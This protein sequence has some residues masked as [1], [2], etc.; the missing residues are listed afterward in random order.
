VVTG[1]GSGI[2]YATVASLTAAGWYVVAVGR[3]PD[4]LAALAE[5]LSGARIATFPGSVSDPAVSEG[6]ADVASARAPLRGWVN[7]AAVFE[8]APLDR[9]DA[10]ALASTLDVN[11]VGA[12][13]GSAVAVRRYLAQGAGGAIVNV[14]SIHASHA[15]RDWAAYDI[16]KAG[17]E[18]LTRSTAVQYA[19]HGIR[20]NAVAPGLIAV[21]RYRSWL[22]SFP[23]AERAE[24]DRQAAALSPTG[25]PGRPSEVAAVVR[26]LLSDAASYVNGATIA[27]DGGSSVWGVDPPGA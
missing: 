19:A 23:R 26:F 27:V 9:L 5:R 3:Q 8:P 15:F 6:A 2:G 25:R 20:A 14:S 12:T 17:L 10:A 21:E 4:R 18:G 7:N 24:R 13:L 22:E 16:A 1:A 11:L